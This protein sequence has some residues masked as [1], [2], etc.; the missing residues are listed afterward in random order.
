[1]AAIDNSA[2][3]CIYKYKNKEFITE[4]ISFPASM[5]SFEDLRKYYGTTKQLV[6]D[7][8]VYDF[9]PLITV[10]RGE[11]YNYKK[12][13]Y[14]YAVEI[15]MFADHGMLIFCDTWIDLLQLFNELNGFFAATTNG[16]VTN[17][18]LTT[19]DISKDNDRIVDHLENIIELKFSEIRNE[20]DRT[21][22]VITI[23]IEKKIRNYIGEAIKQ[24][25]SPEPDI[26]Y[27]QISSFD[28]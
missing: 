17:M 19:V 14:L 8:R 18:E 2:E 9:S 4:N 6:N 23:G 15:D 12:E 28:D 16:S 26:S 13:T 7:S 22:Q 25:R 11:D 10:Y 27:F 1:M 20:L 5:N 3:R 24:L 21:N